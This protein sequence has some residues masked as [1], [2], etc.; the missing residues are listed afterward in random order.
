MKPCERT[1]AREPLND[2]QRRWHYGP[3]RPMPEE[4]AGWLARLLG[5]GH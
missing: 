1:R 2:A 3:L 5:R 4:R